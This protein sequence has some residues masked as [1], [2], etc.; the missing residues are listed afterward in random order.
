MEEFEGAEI[1]MLFAAHD[2][3][4]SE[5]RRGSEDGR[6][7][8]HLDIVRLGKRGTLRRKAAGPVEAVGLQLLVADRV[9]AAC[10]LR[11]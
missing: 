10:P 7:L 11:R 4:C 2:S 1:E 9:H 8:D 6:H 3:N 5:F